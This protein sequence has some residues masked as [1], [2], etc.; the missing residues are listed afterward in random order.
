MRGN[1]PQVVLTRSGRP[2]CVRGFGCLSNGIHHLDA[3]ATVT[4]GRFSM[5]QS[6]VGYSPARLAVAVRGRKVDVAYG[7]PGNNGYLTVRPRL[8]S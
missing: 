5:V 7:D 8:V 2:T 4:R 6:S 1:R 3:N